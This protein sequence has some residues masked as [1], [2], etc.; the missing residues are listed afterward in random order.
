MLVVLIFLRIDSFAKEEILRC[1]SKN[2]TGSMLKDV[3]RKVGFT[4]LRIRDVEYTQE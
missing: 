4:T 1:S 3:L 2:T